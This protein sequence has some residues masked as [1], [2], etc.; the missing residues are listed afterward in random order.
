[1]WRSVA[2]L[3]LIFIFSAVTF[4]LIAI[5]SNQYTESF[6]DAVI[7]DWFSV[8]DNDFT[9]VVSWVSFFGS[10]EVLMILTA[11]LMLWLGLKRKS[12][13]QTFFVAVVMGGGVLLNLSL[14][15]L[16][17]RDRPEDISHFEIFGYAFEWV[18]YSFPSGHAMR[19]FLFCTLMIY[20]IWLYVRHTRTKIIFSLLFVLLI[21]F[22]GISRVM[23]DAHFPSDII[24]AFVASLAWF[25][26]CLAVFRSFYNKRLRKQQ[27]QGL[28]LREGDT[29]MPK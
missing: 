16:F 18:S 10:G 27:D 15:F 7:Y 6:I 25:T 20:L 9:H 26:L 4:T 14:K 11:L 1:M 13:Y 8:V 24:A 3:L 5:S 17:Q 12:Y 2:I 29:D 23:L 19:A 22:I 21:L 28:K